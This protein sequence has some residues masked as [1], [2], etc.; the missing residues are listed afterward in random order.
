MS[1]SRETPK[2]TREETR[3]MRA[4]ARLAALQRDE[5]GGPHARQRRDPVDVQRQARRRQGSVHDEGRRVIHGIP[6]QVPTT[7]AV[8][9]LVERLVDEPITARPTAVHSVGVEGEQ[10]EEQEWDHGS[11]RVA[12]SV[13]RP[14]R[15][16]RHQR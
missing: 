5:V 9:G 7:E 15:F 8:L 2:H 11:A 6:P 10:V 16:A 4:A 13:A 14:G 1:M 3:S 12:G